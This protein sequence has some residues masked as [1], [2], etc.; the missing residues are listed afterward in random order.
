MPSGI[1]K[2]I[3]P[4]WNKGLTK[5]TDARVAKSAVAIGIANSIALIGY[6]HSSD[7]I[8]A[9]CAGQKKRY[10]DPAEHE[11][12]SITTKKAMARPDVKVKH[13]TALIEIQNRPE[14]KL[15]KS[16]AMSGDKNPMFGIHLIGENN[17]NWQGGIGKLPYPF[18]FNN[19]LK[20]LI[21]ERDGYI[22]QLC[23]KTQE[24]NGRKLDI[25]HRNY[26]KDNLELNNLISLCRSCNCKVNYNR[27]YWEN[28]FMIHML[29]VA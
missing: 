2:R 22:C 25:H 24:E 3:K 6:K 26:D 11:K 20:E 4:V 19:K 5:E 12:T 17:P 23:S 10:K 18:A 13:I 27:K 1:Y 28:Y 29:L 9:N 7:H 15:A 8:A 16:V 21:R 14:V